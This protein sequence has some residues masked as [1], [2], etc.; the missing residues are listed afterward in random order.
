MVDRFSLRNLVL[1]CGTNGSYVF[2]KEEQSFFPTPKV[3]VV[4]T[5][6][7]GDSF[8]AAFV[9][10][11]LKGRDQISAHARAV[12]ISAYVCTQHGATP[13][14]PDTLKR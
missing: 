10:S 1:T 9:A 8:T 5:V 4:D 6:G 12:E 13:E 14:L 2:S 3:E 7:A 11:I